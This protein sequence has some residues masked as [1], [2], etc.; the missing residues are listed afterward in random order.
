MSFASHL[1][2]ENEST[3]TTL[4]IPEISRHH[5]NI[6][7]K[8]LE[9]LVRILGRVFNPLN[10]AAIGGLTLNI[11]AVILHA[12][13]RDEKDNWLPYSVFS[14]FAI[15][16]LSSLGFE[17]INSYKLS[18]HSPF[19][20]GESYY[21]H[22]K[23]LT[24][25]LAAVLDVQ[26]IQDS[27]QSFE[28]W[29]MELKRTSHSEL[30]KTNIKDFQAANRYNNVRMIIDN[31]A[32]LVLG[33]IIY[34]GTYYIVPFILLA[35]LFLVK[36]WFSNIEH[37]WFRHEARWR[38]LPLF[39][40]KRLIAFKTL[41]ETLYHFILGTSA[42]ILFAGTNIDFYLFLSGIIS[43]DRNN[44][45]LLCVALDNPKHPFNPAFSYYYSPSFLIPISIFSTTYTI[46]Q[47]NLAYRCC[48]RSKILRDIKRVNQGIVQGAKIG[49]LLMGFAQM[50]L[51]SLCFSTVGNNSSL[52]PFFMTLAMIAS[53]ISIISGLIT[54][55]NTILNYQDPDPNKLSTVSHDVAKLRGEIVNIK[56][57]LLQNV[58][59]DDEH[60]SIAAQHDKSEMD[61]SISNE[62]TSE[63]TIQQDKKSLWN[64]ISSF[65]SSSKSHE[66]TNRPHKSSDLRGAINFQNA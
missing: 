52:P 29:V 19:I 60:V 45:P 42:F 46:I 24:Q 54:G 23:I 9:R 34:P 53:I 4:L 36:T 35:F 10:D 21:G 37:N 16:T 26:S 47:L 14:V 12:L 40:K 1:E 55:V 18:K 30:I 62:A 65:W 6:R 57:K 28:Q 15:I 63:N 66:D 25:E 41:I 5:P 32:T 44:N 20:L 58:I 11:I 49:G 27:Q 8:K 43:E 50:F 13:I 64:S 56:E 51:W 17:I 33:M 48:P 31:I 2:S 61:D 59:N 3:E 22:A 7:R 39:R 38:K